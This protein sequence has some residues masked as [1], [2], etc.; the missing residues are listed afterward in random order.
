MNVGSLV[1]LLNKLA[2]DS[3]NYFKLKKSS[4]ESGEYFFKM[5]TTRANKDNARNFFGKKSELELA[6]SEE[7]YKLLYKNNIISIIKIEDGEYRENHCLLMP[8]GFDFIKL[9]REYDST[10]FLDEIPMKDI[11]DKTNRSFYQKALRETLNRL[12]DP[13]LESEELAAKSAVFA[14]FLLLTGSVSSQ[15]AFI[16]RVDDNKEIEYQEDIVKYLDNLSKKVFE[17]SYDRVRGRQF[18]V[19]DLSNFIR[20][21][22]DLRV[23]YGELFRKEDE[24]I[25]FNITDAEDN[26]S[27][28]S[29][30]RIVN[31]TLK[32]LEH[33]ASGDDDIELAVQRVATDYMLESPLKQ[34]HKTA[35]F[36]GQSDFNYNVM[37]ESVIK[38]YFENPD[39]LLE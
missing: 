30:R 35:L 5:W 31:I 37:L 18:T 22:K 21:N 11:L 25:Y 32:R 15:K 27:L 17:Y 29:L 3:K 7:V 10:K 33:F 1:E 8:L 34:A 9:L 16:L 39:V 24:Y 26:V 28:D 36:V 13:L 23:A 14:L 12:Q 2:M 19:G 20:R 6:L 38:D 4:I